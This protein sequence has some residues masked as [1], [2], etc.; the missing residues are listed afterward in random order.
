MKIL[1]KIL[2]GLL[3]VFVLF[4]GFILICA[5]KPG[6]SAQI[7]DTLK[8]G[9][10]QERNAQPVSFTAFSPDREEDAPAEGT[11]VSD[12]TPGEGAENPEASEDTESET[13]LTN[14]PHRGTPGTN[15][16]DVND[17]QDDPSI[18]GI[19][20]PDEV[21]GKNGYQPIQDNRSEVGED[22][23]ERLL[24]ELGHGETGDGLNF[25]A[26]FYPYYAML[27]SQGQHVY[28]QIYANAKALNERFSP[29]E[30]VSVT[31]LKNVFAAVYND[32]PE[33][34]WMDTAYSCKFRQNGQCAEIDLQF[35]T[36]AKNLEQSRETFEAKA[37]AI[38]DGA[39]DLGSNYEKEKYVHDK[40]IGQVEY[41]ASAQMNQ[42]A[43]SALVNGRTVCAGYAR[44]FQYMLQQLDIP[45]YYCTGFA[46]ESHAWNIVALDDGYY[47][48]DATWDDTGA[49]TY[50]YFNRT[51]G[52]YFDTH[53]RQD[54]SVQLPPC[55]GQAYRN[56]EPE[57]ATDTNREG[58]KEGTDGKRSLQDVGM[59]AESSFSTLE[60]YYNDCYQKV[61]E[62]GKGTYRFQNLIVGD[63]LMEQVYGSY[64]TNDYRQ[65]YLDSAVYQLDAENW[66]IDWE[67][68]ALQE[69][70][71]L[72]THNVTIR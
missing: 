69:N 42:S 26:D 8:F 65:G 55:N 14:T 53:L 63:A 2:Y 50:T 67:I 4:C 52:D 3:I 39:K 40:L 32:H 1:K 7:A 10:E 19:H 38:T 13:P 66:R 47:N 17:F 72:V 51:D 9:E 46:G 59:T 44:A 24:A 6:L 5:L 20:A 54:L 34:F 56:L 64:Q 70:Y 62:N 25:N 15:D 18:A 60:D 61:M 16:W 71:Y 27:D 21:S 48:V 68:E 33:L 23:A 11:V 43:Y 30:N 31:T 22:E 29:I 49:G 37:N 41:A 45:C 57:P 12:S 35:N 58:N 36:T 28:R